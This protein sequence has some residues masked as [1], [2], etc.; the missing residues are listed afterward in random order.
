MSSPARINA[1]KKLGALAMT[2]K[3]EGHRNLHLNM[4]HQ[5]LAEVNA[6]DLILANDRTL[7]KVFIRVLASPGALF[8]GWRMVWIRTPCRPIQT[9]LLNQE[10]RPRLRTTLRRRCRCRRSR[11]Y[12]LS[13]HLPPPQTQ[14][15][16]LATRPPLRTLHTH[17]THPLHT[18][19]PNL[20]PV[21]NTLTRTLTNMQTRIRIRISTPHRSRSPRNPTRR[22]CPIRRAARRAVLRRWIL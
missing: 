22:P 16:H 4:L 20:K 15:N 17:N 3:I 1:R 18:P 12:I 8:L 5:A 10:I 19:N 13:S 6:G 11:I 2:R 14:P 9:A 7:L 21:L